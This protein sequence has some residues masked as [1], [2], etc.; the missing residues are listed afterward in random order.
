MMVA[1]LQ[2]GLTGPWLAVRLGAEPVALEIRR[3]NG[4]LFAVRVPGSEDWLYPSWQ[5]DDE[6]RVR[7]HVARVLAAARDAGLSQAQLEALLRRRVGLAGGQTM[8]DLLLEG[9]EGPLV[10]A[11]K[12]SS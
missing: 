11:I 2:D 4:E 1:H 12:S 6:G 10:S 7:P 3:R 8:L 5:F 9:D